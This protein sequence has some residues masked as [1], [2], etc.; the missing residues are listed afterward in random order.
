MGLSRAPC[1]DCD[2]RGVKL[3]E[4]DRSAIIRFMTFGRH[5]YINMPD[6]KDA[7]ARK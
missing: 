2:G 4:K 5:T 7:K 6:A 3:K 1:S